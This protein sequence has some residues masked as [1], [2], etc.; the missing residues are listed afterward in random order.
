MSSAYLNASDRW[1]H[2]YTGIRL[3]DPN[4]SEQEHRAYDRL[5]YEIVFG[6]SKPEDW[7]FGDDA[8]SFLHNIGGVLAIPKA[9]SFWRGFLLPFS[10]FEEKEPRR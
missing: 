2:K 4:F 1:F 10:P 9:L 7:A 3:P 6:H 5:A 8:E